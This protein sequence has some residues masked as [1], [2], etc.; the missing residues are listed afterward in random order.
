[1]HFNISYK[2]LLILG[3]LSL[4]GCNQSNS[5]SL[6]Q[7]INK[8]SNETIQA[9]QEQ[10]VEAP[11]AWPEDD[12]TKTGTPVLG[13]KLGDSTYESVTHRL[14][15]WDE[16]GANNYNNG[17]MIA[18]NGN[19]YGIDGLQKV[20]YVFST[21]NTLDAVL[22]QIDNR[23]SKMNNEGFKKF[24]GYIAKNGYQQISNQ[25]PFVGNQYSE[26]K[27]PSGDLI[28]INAPHLSFDLYIDYQTANFAKQYQE[29]SQQAKTQ[30]TNTEASQF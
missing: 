3:I 26:F 28:E 20:T 18:T 15:G 2:P 14:S 17:K 21:Q 6:E 1:M 5:N 19:G 8:K 4:A 29:K 23:D 13:F 10:K 12:A 7:N 25:E 27:T 30:K 24:K 16:L 11:K 9:I 22:M